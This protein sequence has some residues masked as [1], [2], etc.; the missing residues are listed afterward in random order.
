MNAL[1][2][3]QFCRNETARMILLTINVTFTFIASASV[4]HVFYVQ[5]KNLINTIGRTSLWTVPSVLSHNCKLLSARIFFRSSWLPV[6]F[7]PVVA[8]IQIESLKDTITFSHLLIRVRLGLCWSCHNLSVTHT[9]WPSTTMFSLLITLHT[10]TLSWLAINNLLSSS[11][12][13]LFSEETFF[14]CCFS[15]NMSY[16]Y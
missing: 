4:S 2:R 10:S 6:E 16:H 9:N 5:W 8:A 1:G 11:V 7:L 14:I 15:P 3:N 12:G 13:D